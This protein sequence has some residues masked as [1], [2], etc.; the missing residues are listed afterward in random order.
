LIINLYGFG[1]TL[2]VGTWMT[3]KVTFVALLIGLLLGLLGAGAKLS[4]FFLLRYGADTYTTVIRGVPELI[5]ILAVYFGSSVVVNNIAG[6]F[7][8]DGYINLN[9]FVAGVLA[10]GFSFGAYATDVFR[11]AILAVPK[12][13]IEAARSFGMSRVLVFRRIMLPQVWRFA[14]P[15]LGNLFL[16]LQKDSA[17]VSVIGLHEV[18]RSATVAVGYTKKP[19]TFYMAAAVIYLCL[20]IVTAA[21]IHHMENRVSRGV[22]RS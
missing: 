13:Q 22:R 6:S 9:A 5:L 8:Y 7:G 14:L 19:F 18:M 4:R 16:I 21:G 2:M 10:L 12:G 3:I 11:G 1:N 20:T 17:L 15:A